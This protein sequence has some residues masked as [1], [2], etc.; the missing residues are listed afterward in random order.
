[1]DYL[2]IANSVPMWIAA[3]LAIILALFQAFVF[4]KKSYETGKTIGLT[5]KQMKSAMK[6]SLITSL[7]P[8]IVILT[9]LLS[10]LVTVGGPMAW[11][12]LSFIGSVGFELMSASVGAEAAGVKMGIDP[13]TTVAFANAVWTM[14][15]GSIGWII[16]ATLTANKMNAV[17]SKAAKGDNGLIKIISVAALLGAFGSLLSGHLVT[18]NKNTIAALAGGMIMLAV[19]LLADKKNVKW[20]KEWGFAIALFGG[21]FVAVVF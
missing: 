3:G 13:M 18:M 21:M 5:E 1:M 16:F 11:M 2:K 12:R 6:S 4:A 10:L 15:L 14:I 7:G 17:Q 9:G 20:L 19:S 8:S